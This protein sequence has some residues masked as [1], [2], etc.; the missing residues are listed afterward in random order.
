MSQYYIVSEEM[1]K[2]KRN[3]SELKEID[4]QLEA[5]ADD[6]KDNGVAQKYLDK[7]R[8]MLHK[9]LLSMQ[10]TDHEAASKIPNAVAGTRG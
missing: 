8:R 7:A 10:Q 5:I 1:K 9:A 4:N 6:Q 3:F 2:A